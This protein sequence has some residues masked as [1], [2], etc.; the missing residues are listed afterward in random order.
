MIRYKVYSA[1]GSFQ[2][3]ELSVQKIVSLCETWPVEFAMLLD[4]FMVPGVFE[5]KFKNAWIELLVDNVKSETSYFE[6]EDPHEARKQAVAYANN[7]H[8]AL[9]S[10]DSTDLGTIHKLTNERGVYA[11]VKEFN[12]KIDIHS[13]GVSIVTEDESFIVWSVGP[14]PEE[15]T[16][17]EDEI[18]N[19]FFTQKR[20]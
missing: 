9:L 6:N 5:F 20:K 19:A 12:Y 2:F 17:R 16:K 15:H 8:E 18:L 13:I 10:V 7:L 11:V 4:Q 3:D 1:N 14:V